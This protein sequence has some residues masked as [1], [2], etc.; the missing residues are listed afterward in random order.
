LQISFSLNIQL[1]LTRLEGCL[2]SLK[3][4]ML[5]SLDMNALLV[6]MQIQRFRETLR[7]LLG[8][9]DLDGSLQTCKTLLAL[10]SKLRLDLL[11]LAQHLILKRQ[12]LLLDKA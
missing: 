1:L 4:L 5:V 10:G 7:H 9:R 8:F 2:E 11:L 6:L 12:I 3:G